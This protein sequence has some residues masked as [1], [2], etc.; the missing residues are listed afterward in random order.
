MGVGQKPFCTL[1]LTLLKAFKTIL[2][3]LLQ[4]RVNCH[5]KAP[6]EVPRILTH[7]QA[8][9]ASLV[10]VLELLGHTDLST[11]KPRVGAQAHVLFGEGAQSKEPSNPIDNPFMCNKKSAEKNKDL[12]APTCCRACT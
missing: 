7:S 6:K 11:K 12:Q 8:P 10:S 4:T 1:V 5:P 2:L 9:W 3:R